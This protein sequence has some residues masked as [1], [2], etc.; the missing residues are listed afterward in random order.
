MGMTENSI[1]E[2][3][4]A[5]RAGRV[6]VVGGGFAGLAAA[7]ELVRSG[8]QVTVFEQSATA[9][10]RSGGEEVEGYSIERQLPLLYGSDHQL[11]GWIRDLGL[12]QSLLPARPVQEAQLSGSSVRPVDLASPRSIARIEGV[13]WREALRLVRLPRLMNRYRSLLDPGAP[14][15]AADLDYRSASDFGK[16]YFGQSVVERFVGPAL[17]AYGDPDELS[18]VAFLLDWIAREEGRGRTL[19]LRG[20]LHR[21]ASAAA[22]SLG[23]QLR[24]SVRHIE[25]NGR[26]G[27]SISVAGDGGEQSFEAEAV[28]VATSP[29]ET[30][31][32][33]GPLLA[34]AEQDVLG[35][36][37]SGPEMTLSIALDRELTGIPQLIRVPRGERSSIASLLL[38]PGGPG[39]RAPLGCGLAT[40]SATAEFCHAHARA[41]SDVVEKELLAEFERIYP[42]G[43]GRAQFT[44]IQRSEAGVP[45]FLVGSLRS[46]RRFALVQEDRRAQGRRLY[47]AGDH[48]V[49]PRPE[50]AVAS[51]RRAAAALLADAG[52]PGA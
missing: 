37:V 1:D 44:R 24:K 3:A 9:G 7:G 39:L 42:R 20:S 13:R 33:A 5:R 4:A 21:L 36:L 11:P 50:H 28:V 46:L 23:V 18:R 45:Q 8:C 31:R 30:R 26:G 10:G 22:Q 19:A 51:G 34:L 12:A 6:A 16:L 41:A 14:E 40:L 52:Q 47:F 43:T 38:D 17:S 15:K 32:V 48:L 29:A 25:N 2:S 27:F 35:E 49:G